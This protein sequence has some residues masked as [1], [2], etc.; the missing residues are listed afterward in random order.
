MNSFFFSSSVIRFSQKRLYPA[1]MQAQAAGKQTGIAKQPHTDHPESTHST[2]H[3]AMLRT[4][5]EEERK[6]G[7]EPGAHGGEEKEKMK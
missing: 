5:K 4:A 1:R 7:E 2:H 3:P 6:D